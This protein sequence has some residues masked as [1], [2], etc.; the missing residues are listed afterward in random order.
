MRFNCSYFN[1]LLLYSFQHVHPSHL[2]RYSEL[3]SQAQKRKVIKQP[4]SMAVN[5]KCM[6]ESTLDK[7][8]INFITR[9]LRPFSTVESKEFQEIIH[10]IQP[11]YTIISGPTVYNRTDEAA[12]EFKK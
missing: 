5:S 10:G 8:V 12:M 1:V 6:P 9:G 11:G 7:L 2:Q 3:T 4:K